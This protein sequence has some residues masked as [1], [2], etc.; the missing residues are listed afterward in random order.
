MHAI[1]FVLK[2]II[3]IFLKEY[4]SPVPTIAKLV[5]RTLIV[6]RAIKQPI[7]EY[8]TPPLKDVYL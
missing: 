1:K 8:S 3:L 6:W 7:W 5:T 2:D 4:A